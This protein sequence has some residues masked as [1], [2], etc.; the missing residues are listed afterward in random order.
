MVLPF[1][2][3]HRTCHNEQKEKSNFLGNASASPAAAKAE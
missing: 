3:T 1:H 2:S